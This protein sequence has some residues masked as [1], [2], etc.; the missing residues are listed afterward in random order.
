MVPHTKYKISPTKTIQKNDIAV[1]VFVDTGHAA[2]VFQIRAYFDPSEAGSIGPVSFDFGSHSKRTRAVKGNPFISKDPREYNITRSSTINR[3]LKGTAARVSVELNGA[4]NICAAKLWLGW[5][6]DAHIGA[7]GACVIVI[8]YRATRVV[9]KR[10]SR[11]HFPF[12]ALRTGPDG[13]LIE[14]R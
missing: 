7:V 12:S 10:V 8:S 14:S 4:A 9:K 1:L 6:H 11:P 5:I 13:L 2:R 3:R